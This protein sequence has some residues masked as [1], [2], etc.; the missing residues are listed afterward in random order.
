MKRII[1]AIIFNIAF[2]N[3]S[4]SSGIKDSLQ[5]RVYFHTAGTV[6]E[7]SYRQ[8]AITLDSLL[9]HLSRIRQKMIVN[10][11]R[12]SSGASPEGN[13][14]FNQW[15]S[16][17]RGESLRNYLQKNLSLPDSVF[18]IQDQGENWMELSQM[19]TRSSLPAQSEILQIL[20][21]GMEPV[22]SKENNS[23]KTKL[24]LK[25]YQRGK[26]WR[27]MNRNFFPELRSSS[28]VEYEYSPR[29]AMQKD[30]EI[31]GVPWIQ[32]SL[33]VPMPTALPLIGLTE[34]EEDRKRNFC[35]A[36]KSNLLY[37]AVLLPNIGVEFH[38]GRKWTLCANWQYSWWKNDRKH[39]YWRI[40]GGDIGIRK[41]FG[42]AASTHLFTGHHL[43]L[44]GQI[45]TYDVE[46][47]KR[48]LIGGIPGGTIWD[49][50]H[51][52]GGL[53]YGYSQ[54]V[55]KRFHLDFSL[56]AGYLGGICYE[57]LPM[58]DHY[59]WQATR[60]RSW[61]GPTKAEISL[62]WLIGNNKINR[63]MKGGKQ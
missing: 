59:V 42:K 1:L 18:I 20:Q 15:L 53:E 52:G 39:L 54:P 46:G 13:R 57:Y 22:V 23:E 45:L 32:D 26:V 11:I 29:P 25:K 19:V 12:I 7:K 2:W 33:T 38:L 41:Y 21:H 17:T 31:C 5:Y 47:G 16:R 40:Y 62:V 55:G 10:K 8:N 35:M 9:S 3:A 51:Y 43:G 63:N 34:K 48:G 49:K 56:G 60:K 4:H 44:Y 27:Y 58:D 6:I 36:L 14:K 37:D 24:L 30:P 61:L 28:V 50:A